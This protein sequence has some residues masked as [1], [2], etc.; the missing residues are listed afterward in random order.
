[1]HVGACGEEEHHVVGERLGRLGHGLLLVLL[2]L[3]LVPPGEVDVSGEV[4]DKDALLHA[5]GQPLLPVQGLATLV[6]SPS[7]QLRSTL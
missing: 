6:Q 7:L 2:L 5:P 1:Q 3:L 4:P